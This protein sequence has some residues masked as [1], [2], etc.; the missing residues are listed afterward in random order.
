MPE[1]T[2]HLHLIADYFPSVSEEM[3][4]KYAHF[5]RLIL[6]WNA[7]INLVSRKDTDQL[8]RNHILHSLAIAKVVRFNPGA[9]VLDVG[10][11]GGFPGIPLAILFPETRFTLVDSIAKK[12]R[13]VEDI[14]TVMQLDNVKAVSGRA[15]NIEGEYDYV[16][17][18]ATAP[19]NDLVDWTYKKVK[20]G[21]AGSLPNGWFVLKGGDLKE[22]MKRYKREVDITKLETIFPDE[23]FRE[24]VVVYLPRQII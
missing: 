13:V 10:T 7:K 24:K 8:F 15:E 20:P 6:D 16:V 2:G 11:G 18:R 4:D 12:I 5:L 3:L 14:R 1:S 23:Y 19:M 21:Q 17:S 9:R 22:E